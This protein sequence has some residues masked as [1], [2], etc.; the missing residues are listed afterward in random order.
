VKTRLRKVAALGLLA[1]FALWVAVELLDPDCTPESWLL[2]K[3]F[4]PG[5]R[6]FQLAVDLEVEGQAVSIVR[7][8][9]CKPKFAHSDMSGGL[10]Y[11]VGW[12]P[13]RY[14]VSERLKDGSGIMVVVPRACSLDDPPSPDF[15][16]LILWAQDAGNPQVL[17][18]YFD[19]NRLLGSGLRVRLNR[20]ELVQN[21][22]PSATPPEDFADL[23]NVF[24]K[25]PSPNGPRSQFVALAALSLP[26]GQR[27]D[28]LAG[29]SLDSQALRILPQPVTA[30]G[31]DI[32]ELIIAAIGRLSGEYHPDL[33][34]DL[35]ERR[36]SLNARLTK[37]HAFRPTAEQQLE[38][39]DTPTG[40]VYF[41][42][43]DLS[44]CGQTRQRCFSA[45]GEATI[46]SD[47]R[48]Q[49]YL[50]HD[51]QVFV[52]FESYLTLIRFQ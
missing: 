15:I 19:N 12:Y 46:I 41:V 2:L 1:F 31:K 38:F 27:P 52:E 51:G 37:L 42:R 4:H 44:W 29:A 14:L 23:L 13:S 8:I 3:L 18:A 39:T 32:S 35:A 7:V 10:G 43:S 47:N 30:P 11:S 48:T 26:H 45:D 16:P 20:F 25:D 40:V 24:S 17:E 50:V 9:E 34:A 28:E 33:P 6:Y 21:S 36:R 22:E 49:H 5:P